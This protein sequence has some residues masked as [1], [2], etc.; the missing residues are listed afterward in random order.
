MVE[1]VIN[2]ATTFPRQRNI[3]LVGKANQVDETGSTYRYLELTEEDANHMVF[4][5]PSGFRKT[6]AMKALIQEI[7]TKT[8]WGRDR[9][10]P[11]IVVFEAKYDR[12]KAQAVKNTFITLLKEKGEKWLKDRFG[13]EHYK[14]MKFYITL[15]MNPGMAGSIGLMGDFALAWG[16]ILGL[17]KIDSRNTELSNFGLRP[18]PFPMRRI[19]FNPT[20]ELHHIAYDSGPEAEIIATKIKYSRLNFEDLAKL[21]NLNNYT[22]YSGVIKEAWDHLKIRDPDE[23]L[24]R[25]KEIYQ[26]ML[27]FLEIESA[28]PNMSLWG[29]KATMERLKSNPLFEKDGKDLIDIIDNDKINVIDFSQNSR[30]TLEEKKLIFRKI[31][32]Y[33]M[34][35]YA[36]IKETAIFI[37]GDEIQKYLDDHTGRKII[38]SLFREGRSNQINLF[39]ATQYLHSLPSE[40]IYGASH[41]A[42]LGFLTSADD[43]RLLRKLIPDF[44][45]KYHQPLARTPGEVEKLRREHKGRGYIIINKLFT[46]RILFRPSQTL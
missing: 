15:L 45:L 33:L 26:E 42:I 30:L 23:V 32:E 20:R 6:T 11:L 4:L 38:S 25:A 41:I 7:W 1:A 29:V 31:I 8:S 34:N 27:E 10:K 13:E 24:H 36:Q 5:G 19:V 14:E 17:Q 18:E 35:E 2:A 44:E 37:V 22:I 43:T 46:E 3:I 28:K 12:A 39:A 21:L 16:N 40:L 9:E